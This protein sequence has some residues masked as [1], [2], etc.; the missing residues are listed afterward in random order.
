[1]PFIAKIPIYFKDPVEAAHQQTFEIQ[2]RGDAQIQ[3]HGQD[4]VIGFK[5]PGRGAPGNGLHHGGFHFQEA[6]LVH[7]LP[8]E[9][10][11]P[12]AGAEDVFDLGIDD[13]VEIPA[14]IAEFHVAETVVF[15]GQ[16]PDG[17]GQQDKTGHGQGK[18]CGLGAEETAG[19]ADNIA[20]IQLFKE[21]I[22]LGADFLTLKEPCKRPPRPGNE[23]R[24]PCRT[25]ASTPGGRPD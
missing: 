15:F 22:G 19:E 7:K 6:P 3:G 21:G 8:H 16:G 20:Q 23:K 9:P 5:R 12:G 25:A 13:E 11:D 4:V 17:F 1:M 24:W 10:D 14:A 2:F 18:F